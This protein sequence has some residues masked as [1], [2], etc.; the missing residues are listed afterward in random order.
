[1][2]I[3][4]AIVAFFDFI[5]AFGATVMMPIILLVLGNDPVGRFFNRFFTGRWIEKLWNRMEPK[6]N[7]TNHYD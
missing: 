3:L 2:A 4:N 1:M 7:R 5:S 6:P